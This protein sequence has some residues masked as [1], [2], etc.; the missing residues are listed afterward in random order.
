MTKEPN[1]QD[2]ILPKNTLYTGDLNIGIEQLPFLKIHKW[3]VGGGEIPKDEKLYNDLITRLN[4]IAERLLQKMVDELNNF[5]Y[6]YSRKRVH[7]NRHI[8]PESSD[9]FYDPTKQCQE[10]IK[11]ECD[12][13]DSLC[14]A[15]SK[16]TS[17]HLKYARPKLYKSLFYA[18]CQLYD[19]AKEFRDMHTKYGKENRQLIDQLSEYDRNGVSR[20]RMLLKRCSNIEITLSRTKNVETKERKIH[21][22]K[23]VIKDNTHNTACVPKEFFPLVLF[24][25]HRN[26]DLEWMLKANGSVLSFSDEDDLE[27]VKKWL[28]NSLVRE[29]RI[30]S[31]D[32]RF[33]KSLNGLYR[34][35]IDCDIVDNI[36]VSTRK[37]SRDK[38]IELICTLL[39]LPE[40][41]LQP[42]R[43]YIGKR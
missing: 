30:N 42:M 41:A 40:S 26:P 10:I 37:S 31:Y 12:H 20:C 4:N 34:Y 3:R 28:T 17:L 29:N 24:D 8:T 21:I 35:I 18:F 22:K 33:A 9:Y 25:L 1:I 39:D 14:Q 43:N 5:L 27:E 23:I 36:D 38:A 7:I 13:I 19:T 6:E 2:Y 16:L 11:E 32:K 15:S